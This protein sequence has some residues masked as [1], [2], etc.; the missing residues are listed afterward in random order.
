VLGTQNG[1]LSAIH[2]SDINTGDTD[3]GSHG[4]KH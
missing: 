4:G 1:V 3:G 2:D